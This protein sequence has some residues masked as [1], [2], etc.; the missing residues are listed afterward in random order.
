MLLGFVMRSDVRR[1]SH[2]RG[3]LE[4]R[5][6][7]PLVSRRHGLLSA[8]LVMRGGRNVGSR[9]IREL[10]KDGVGLGRAVSDRTFSCG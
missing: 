8:F 6:A 2:C 10:H 3:H 5:A 4:C 7:A 9:G 1:A